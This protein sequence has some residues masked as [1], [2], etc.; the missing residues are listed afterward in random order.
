M[1]LGRLYSKILID[2]PF[3]DQPIILSLNP[4]LINSTKTSYD[5]FSENHSRPSWSQH[6]FKS[7]PR[8]K[9]V[10]NDFKDGNKGFKY[11]RP[12]CPEEPCLKSNITGKN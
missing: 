8:K 1:A 10:H 12:R 6:I 2:Q 7:F 5:F 4:V 9:D 3:L 11:R